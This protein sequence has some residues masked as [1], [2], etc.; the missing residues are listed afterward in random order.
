MIAK[1]LIKFLN[2]SLLGRRPITCVDARRG[3][4]GYLYGFVECLAPM[5]EDDG[6]P[7]SSLQ[8]LGIVVYFVFKEGEEII[9]KLF[10]LMR[11]DGLIFTCPTDDTRWHPTED[12]K[13]GKTRVGESE[14]RERVEGR[15]SQCVSSDNVR[16]FRS[17]RV[18]E[19]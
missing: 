9:L 14:L 16:S 8:E 7:L 1:S 5:Y 15:R 17:D 11:E 18:R 2:N 3:S 10:S 6:T 12:T 13:G 4:L 19:A